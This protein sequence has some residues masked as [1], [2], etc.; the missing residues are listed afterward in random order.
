MQLAPSQFRLHHSRHLHL[1]LLE[2][3]AYISIYSRFVSRS[4]PAGIVLLDDLPLCPTVPDG[5][6][7]VGILLHSF[8]LDIFLR[9][10]SDPEGVQRR[11]YLYSHF[12]RNPSACFLLSLKAQT[13]ACDS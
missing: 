8:V 2:A 3:T 4:L 1:L 5:N 10:F 13:N 11:Y 6:K 9:R 7:M 12:D